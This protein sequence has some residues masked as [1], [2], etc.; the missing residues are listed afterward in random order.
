MKR[1]TASITLC[2]LLSAVFCSCSK[3]TEYNP[4]PIDFNPVIGTQVRAEIDY[5]EFPSSESFQIWGWDDDSDLY[6]PGE[7]ISNNAGV[8]RS[9]VLW[10]DE[11]DV[12]FQA[13]ATRGKSLD[14]QVSDDCL[15]IDNFESPASGIDLLYAAK[16]YTACRG[17]YAPVQLSF[18]HVL[19][20]V[21]FRAI[22][23]MAD[24]V[25]MRLDRL[26]LHSVHT[27]ASFRTP[28]GEVEWNPTEAKVDYNILTPDAP[29]SLGRELDYVGDYM[30]FVPQNDNIVI[31]LEFSFSI[32]EGEV[33][34]E[35]QHM[36]TE[37]FAADWAT[38]N[39]ITYSLV[40]T[41]HEL[42]VTR[43]ISNWNNRL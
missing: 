2:V 1:L 22:N 38:G 18:D 31:D 24:D 11:S 27:T 12:A 5:S 9:K 15:S 34:V 41:Q 26:T 13:L 7:T 42:T 30:L 21:D 8:W 6:I 40:I 3:R 16:T 10:P 32:D 20:K 25:M 14:V 28:G 17:D 19:S 33:W 29:L 39:Y 35:H 4:G 23:G 37:P 36:T 43:G